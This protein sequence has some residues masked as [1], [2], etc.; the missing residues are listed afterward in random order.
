MKSYIVKSI[1][2]LITNSSSEVFCVISGEDSKVLDDIH[3]SLYEFFECWKQE[4][5][6]TVCISPFDPEDDVQ[7]KF[8]VPYSKSN[9]LDIYKIV[10]EAFCRNKPI[11]TKFHYERF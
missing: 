6:I 1:S 7:F 11:K 4:D 10:I 2:D 8:E 3:T 5:E 9:F